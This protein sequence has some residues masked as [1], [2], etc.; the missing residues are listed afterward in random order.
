LDISEEHFLDNILKMNRYEVIK[1]LTKMTRTVDKE[2]DW[3]VQPLVVNAFY[4]A[5]GN[6]VIFPMGI[7]RTPIFTPDRPKYLNYGMLG[8]VIGHE[9]THGFDNSGRKF[10]KVGNLTQWWSDEIVEK[11]KEQAAC[12]VEQYS[13]LPIDIVGQN[14]DF[15]LP[16][17]KQNSQGLLYLTGASTAVDQIEIFTQLISRTEYIYKSIKMGHHHDSQLSGSVNFF[18][19][20]P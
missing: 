9:I 19:T 3:F 12:F 5:T 1:E 4:E 15:N 2:R 18:R 16:T 6:A 8:V 11:F 10:D 20:S 7:L 14:R 17:S 13:Q